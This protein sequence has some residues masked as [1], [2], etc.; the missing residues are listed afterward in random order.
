MIIKEATRR[1]FKAVFDEGKCTEYILQHFPTENELKIQNLLKQNHIKYKFQ[2]VFFKTFEG[3]RNT[4]ECYYIA[5]FWLYKKRLFIEVPAGI[6]Q[7]KPKFQD[8]RTYNA[9]EVF[10]KAQCIQLKEEDI[11]DAVFLD[12]FIS[13]LK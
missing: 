8:F 6:R 12:Q 13:L 5:Q 11:E 9:L 7:K 3:K 2:K 10:P 4:A 1:A